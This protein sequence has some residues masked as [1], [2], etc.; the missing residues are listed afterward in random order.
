MVI[1]IKKVN[2]KK[3]RNERNNVRSERVENRKQL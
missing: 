1:I 3:A 2:K